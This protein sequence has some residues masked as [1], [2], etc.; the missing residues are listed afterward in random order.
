AY[1]DLFRTVGRQWAGVLMLYPFPKQVVD[2][3][4]LNHVCVSLVEQRGAK[5]L[6]CVDVNHYQGIALIVNRL[7]ELGHRRIGFYS[8]SY[9]VEAS[10]SLRRLGAYFEKMT[11]L[12]LR[13]N[14]EDMINAHPERMVSLK[15]SFDL[16]E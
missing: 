10:W 13:I 2:E 16:A 15:E 4:L 14:D 12:G 1:V 8:K 6:D 11:Q 3:L 7:Y 5:E 9:P